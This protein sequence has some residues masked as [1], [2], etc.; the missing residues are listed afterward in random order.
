MEGR[1]VEGGFVGASMVRS[2]SV[3][4]RSEMVGVKSRTMETVKGK[5]VTGM[6]SMC[7]EVVWKGE[8]S[9]VLPLLHY[10]E[11]RSINPFL[12]TL[13]WSCNV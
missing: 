13:G 6:D 2:L 5:S 9:L 4:R 10:H 12:S 3:V 1:E 11:E 8:V 7:G